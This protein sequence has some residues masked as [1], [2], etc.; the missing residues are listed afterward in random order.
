MPDW[1]DVTQIGLALPEVEEGTW[2]GTAALKVAGKGFCRKRE[3][4][5]TLVV[6]VSDFDEKEALL[7]SDAEA[8]TTT[9]HYDGSAIV[10]VHLEK[11]GR[12][13]FAELLEDAWRIKAPKRLLRDRP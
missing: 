2:Y 9:P 1:S 11:V 7:Q 4:P 10:L 13:E 12:K 5:D 6:P 8:F 3:D